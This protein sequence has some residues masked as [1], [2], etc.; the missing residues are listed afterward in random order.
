MALIG[1]DLQFNIRNLALKGEFITHQMGL[2]RDEEVTNYGFYSQ[3]LYDFGPIFMVGRFGLYSP[4]EEDADDLTR[5]SGGI[6]WKIYESCEMRFEYQAN[7]G[8]TGNKGLL[9]LVAGF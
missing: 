6:G 4:D 7:S 3:G 9:Q 2:S 8:D 1:A 5:V